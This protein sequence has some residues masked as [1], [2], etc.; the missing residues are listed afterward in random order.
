MPAHR[1]HVKMS[2]EDVPPQRLQLRLF[3]ACPRSGSSLLMRIFSESSVCAVACGL[4]LNT[5]A[6][7]G[8]L[9]LNGTTFDDLY[10]Q[11]VLPYANDGLGK[12]FLISHQEFGNDNTNEEYS[13]ESLLVGSSY[14]SAARPVFLIRDPIRVFDSWK[15]VG[16]TKMKNLIDYYNNIFQLLDQD[17]GG[18]VTCLVYKD[19]FKTHLKRLPGFAPIGESLSTPRCSHSQNPLEN[20]F[21]AVTKKGRSC[22]KSDN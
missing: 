11:A 16:W 7:Q 19:S 14:Y 2:S 4:T 22:Q 15:N 3:A 6:V 9:Q 12:Q 5:N 8:I 18:S 21:I 1:P 20:F 17:L 10:Q 13:S